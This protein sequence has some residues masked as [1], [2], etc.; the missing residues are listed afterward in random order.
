MQRQ[1]SGARHLKRAGL[2]KLELGRQICSLPI[3]RR[4]IMNLF[5]YLFPSFWRDRPNNQTIRILARIELLEITMS[6]TVHVAIAAY[7]ASQTAFNQ[8]L[9]DGLDEIKAGVVTLEQK[10]TELQAS[11][12]SISD[13]DQ[14]TLDSL[15]TSVAALKSK[16][17]DINNLNPP[18]PPVVTP[19]PATDTPAPVATSGASDTGSE[20][21]A[22]S[23]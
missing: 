19:P 6:N 1:K 18:A 7:A 11:D 13:E 23:S 17:D 22:G 8:Q 9:S 10:I 15:S 4:K 16:V 12:G 14:A 3:N 5:K 20:A 2:L 21:A